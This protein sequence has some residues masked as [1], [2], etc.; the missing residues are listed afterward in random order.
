MSAV[1]LSFGSPTSGDGFDVTN[2]V[3]EI[4]SN[5]QSVETPWKNQLTNLQSQDTALTS[6][7]T[8]LSSLSTALQSLTN[9][10]GVLSEK[11]G[12]SSDTSVLELTS[13]STSAV[14][15]SHTI[16]V[17]SLAQTSS[18]YTN[19][20]S[21]NDTLSG[22]FT[23]QVGSGS[24]QTIQL[25]STNNTLS[26]LASA[27][28]SGSYGVTANVITDSS[29][30]RLE[31]VSNT[32]GSGGN[33]VLGGTLTDSTAGSAMSFTQAQAGKDASLTVDGIAI[34][35]SSNT[36]SNALP[37]V[38]FQ[39]LS[40]SPG[41]DVQVQITNDNSA[42]E[43]AVSSFVTAYNTVIGDLNTQEGDTSTGTPEP[44]YGNS[45]ISN[46]QQSLES[47][48]NFAQASNATSTAVAI[49]PSDQV[50]GSVSISVGGT[51]QTVSVGS[52]DDTLQ[53]LADAINSAGIGVTAN[54]ITSGN[55]S[56]LSLV[57]ATSG[58]SG[59]ISVDSNLN[60]VTTGQ[61]I[62]FGSSVSNAVTSAS[63]LGIT[64]NSDGT[65]SLNTDT[66]DAA[67][68][69]N[70]QS[71][72][73]FLQ[74]SGAFTSF[75]GNLTNVIEGLSS[76]NPTG[77]LSLALKQNSTVES[78]LNQNITNEENLIA[79]QKQTLTAELNEANETLEEIPSQLNQ[80]NEMYSAITGYNTGSNG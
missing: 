34:T 17:N 35:S 46:L 14:A 23:I 48:L 79:S 61:A 63:Q 72:V 44:L 4:V 3:N 11:Q 12:S 57:N 19:S 37:G 52:N 51:T 41:T 24:A 1:G 75:G 31:L 21:A 70:Y 39:L 60:D 20:I 45:T 40:A 67:L 47:A 80:I 65:L 77:A 25:N 29:G 2:T 66:L 50:S 16:V 64:V 18:Y 15:G 73:N 28:N 5:M 69:S 71:V 43:S 30:S 55:E 59:G 33:I 76:S 36:V 74:P 54:I 13:A 9:F 32:S 27:I 68:N 26:S 56:T 42:V 49:T 53:G 7:G 22:S 78:Q 62:N 6:I 58:S 10:E 8:D 38:T